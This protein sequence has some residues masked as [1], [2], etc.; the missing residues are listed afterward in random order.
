MEIL[1]NKMIN[2]LSLIIT[3]NISISETNGTFEGAGGF[4][5]VYLLVFKFVAWYRSRGGLSYTSDGGSRRKF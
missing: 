3:N 5:V 4:I 1:E 2:K